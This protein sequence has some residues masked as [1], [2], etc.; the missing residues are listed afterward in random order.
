MK[1]WSWSGGAAAMIAGMLLSACSGGAP[2]ATGGAASALP[3]A[4]AAMQAAAKP[5]KGAPC[6]A[7]QI[8]YDFGGRCAAAQVTARGGRAMIPAYRGYLVK[9]I[10]GANTG[11]GGKRTVFVVRDAIG[12][13]DITGTLNGVAWQPLTGAGTAF[14]YLAVTNTS[15]A[16]LTFA[17]TP[18]VIIANIRHAGFPGTTCALYALTASGWA[19][20]GVTATPVS[21]G[22]KGR[23]RVT[24][25]A[26]A[27]P[28]P[29]TFASGP[30]YFGFACQ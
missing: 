12:D 17:K 16:T 25:P 27:L 23:A 15:A 13:T 29:V 18:A 14:L 10:F 5:G 26:T 3:A 28:V 20:T 1:R 19:P 4:P 8:G 2:G 22:K 30:T 9:G 7:A 6:R 24:F 21:A 11:A